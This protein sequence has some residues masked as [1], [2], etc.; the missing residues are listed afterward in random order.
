[1][2]PVVEVSP[3]FQW[4]APNSIA[5]IDCEFE[6]IDNDVHVDWL[7][8]DEPLV[9]NQRTTIMNNGTRI[10]IGELGRSD[11]GA[12]SCRVANKA[13]SAVGRD[14]ASLLV[15]VFMLLSNKEPL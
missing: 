7:K 5:T 6:N 8:N 14:I 13:D 2:P 1:M 3:R 4:A 9:S 11:T 15:Q 10:Q 12:Y